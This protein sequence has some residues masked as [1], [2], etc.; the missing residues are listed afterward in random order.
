MKKTFQKTLIAAS[1]GIV[2]LSAAGTA[3]ANSLLF[4]YFTTTTGAQS[5]LSLSMGTTTTN[6]AES[7][8]Y[9]YN[10]G[11]S[12]I[13]FDAVGK[14]TPNDLLQHS[15][16]STAAG[17]FGKAVAA[18]ASTP[19]Y[20]PLPNMQGFLVVSNTTTASQ[21]ISGDMAIIDPTTGLSIS[22]A[23]ITGNNPNTT[24][25]NGEGDF[26]NIYYG[27]ATVNPALPNPI[28]QRTDALN[29]NLSFYSSSIVTTSWYAVVAGNMG[30]AITAGANWLG[31]VTLTNNGGV[32]NNDESLLSG[33]VTKTIVCAG[34]VLPTDLMTAAQVAAVGP[35]GGLIHATGN[36]VTTAGTSLASGLIMSKIQTILPA[37]GSPFAGKTLLHREQS[38][39]F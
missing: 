6:A 5:V 28:A 9:V 14:M 38:N 27:G 24:A 29:F 17:G 16:A 35:N 3:S 1:V 19:V 21:Q 2:M 26:S 34:T 33:T 12:C 32:Y 13:H 39:A 15:V 8:H 7:L 22:Y 31:Q 11:P 30:P 10:Y 20:F 4:P 25:G 37:A 18:D 36:P 23:G